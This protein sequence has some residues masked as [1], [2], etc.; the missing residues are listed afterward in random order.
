MK[1][2]LNQLKDIN[3]KLETSEYNEEHNFD[4]LKKAMKNIHDRLLSVDKTLFKVQ[5]E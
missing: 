3:T 4:K 1:S 2:E 5:G